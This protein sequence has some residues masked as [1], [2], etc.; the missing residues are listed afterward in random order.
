MNNIINEIMNLNLCRKVWIQNSKSKY[1]ITYFLNDK[2]KIFSIPIE[3][4]DTIV[5]AFITHYKHNVLK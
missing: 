5:E 4:K 2:Y 1:L 3:N